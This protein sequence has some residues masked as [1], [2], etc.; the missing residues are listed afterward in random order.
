[1][2]STAMS[3]GGQSRAPAEKLPGRGWV[4]IASTNI[5]KTIHSRWTEP[6]ARSQRQGMGDSSTAVE[7][8]NSSE[9][10]SAPAAHRSTSTPALVRPDYKAFGTEYA[11]DEV[12]TTASLRVSV[13][14][15]TFSSPLISP[16]GAMSYSRSIARSARSPMVFRPVALYM[17]CLE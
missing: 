16:A 12:Q 1:M 2:I 7:V 11:P 8:R 4:T 10:A 9:T 14:C 13:S 3:R 5:M 17:A 6:T 15:L